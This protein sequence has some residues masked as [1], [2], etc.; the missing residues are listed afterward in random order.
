MDQILSG[1]YVA[2][3]AIAG[4]FFLRF[5]RASRDRLFIF[6]SVAFWVLGL[7]RLML[8]V[9]TVPTEDQTYLYVIRLIAFL[10][11]LYAIIDKNLAAKKS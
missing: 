5:W 6:F 1:M 3:Y 11:I 9:S 10:I 4:L 7:Q 8:A 2:G